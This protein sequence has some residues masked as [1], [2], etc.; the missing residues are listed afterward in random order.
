MKRPKGSTFKCILGE[1]GDSMEIVEERM[2]I[3]KLIEDGKIPA[4]EGA[5]LLAALADSRRTPPA[6]PGA[7]PAGNARWFRVRVTDV[8][9]GKTKINVNLPM[10]LVNV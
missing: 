6:Q 2:K 7:G 1:P 3:L 4:E 9:T 10:S 5:K 8:A